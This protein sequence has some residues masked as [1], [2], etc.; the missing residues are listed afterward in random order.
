MALI[1]AIILVLEV[2]FFLA[3]VAGMYFWGACFLIMMVLLCCSRNESEEYGPKF[4]IPSSFD[5]IKLRLTNSFKNDKSIRVSAIVLIFLTFGHLI[6]SQS[7]T[8]SELKKGTAPAIRL[9]NEW[10]DVVR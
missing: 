6:W 4:S 10:K 9:N 7:N 8:L 2:F 1:M 3:P 5:T